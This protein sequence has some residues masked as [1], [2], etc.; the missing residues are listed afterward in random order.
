MHIESL[1]I[2]FSDI[3]LVPEEF[4]KISFPKYVRNKIQVI[5]NTPNAAIA[6]KNLHRKPDFMTKPK[7]FYA[8]WIDSGRGIDALIALSETN[9]FDVS[10]AGDGDEALKNRLIATNNIE[11]LGYLNHEQ[12]LEKTNDSDFIYAVYSPTKKINR[13][14]ASNKIAESLLLGK[15][16]IVNN[17]MEISKLLKSYD[18][19]IAIDYEELGKLSVYITELFNS[20]NDYLSMVCNSKKLYKEH[21]SWDI[22]KNK[23][24]NIYKELI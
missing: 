22:V 20:P 10:V 23:I 8:G 18:T 21:Y 2:L 4:R 11:Y 5:Q 19:C 12:I 6:P 7:I 1:F 14:A 13:F 3:T 15:P 9:L 16:V 17:E 24:I